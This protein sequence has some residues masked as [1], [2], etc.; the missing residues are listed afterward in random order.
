MNQTAVD[1]FFSEHA[2]WLFENKIEELMRVFSVPLHLYFADGEVTLRSFR[3]LYLM[4]SLHREQMRTNGVT[5]LSASVVRV[6]AGIGEKV[7][8][9][10]RWA[11]VGDTETTNTIDYV[12]DSSGGG[13]RILMTDFGI[14][15]PRHFAYLKGLEA[16]R[17]G[18]AIS[19]KGKGLERASP[20]GQSA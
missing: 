8:V 5:A 12:L 7:L 17:R 9:K 14:P 18:P 6:E 20:D 4:L 2:A 1:D 3:E 15:V 13:L 19:W 11:S 16:L 10:V